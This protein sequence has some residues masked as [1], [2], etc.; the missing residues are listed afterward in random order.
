VRL[1][2]IKIVRMVV[3]NIKK[4]KATKLQYSCCHATSSIVA[5]SLSHAETGSR[6]DHGP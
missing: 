4:R 6:I 2:R 5:W 3:M 1:K